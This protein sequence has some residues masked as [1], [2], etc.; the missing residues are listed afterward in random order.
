MIK[1]LR[2]RL[3]IRGKIKIGG[4]G[5]EKKSKGSDKTYRR[6]VKY[7]HFV[8][9]RTDRGEDGNY[10]RD[11]D[12]MKKYGDNP[13]ELNV[14]FASNNIRDV[15]DDY[16]ALHN[17]KVFVCKGDGET[18]EWDE[19]AAGCEPKNLK[20]LSKGEDG[21]VKVRCNRLTCPYMKPRKGKDALCKPNAILR[22]MIKEAQAVGAVY[23]FRTTSWNSTAAL[24]ASF[25]SIAS[26]TK[27]SVVQR[28]QCDATYQTVYD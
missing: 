18:A 6:S 12:L 10:I 3:A 11:E 5:E 1:G 16:L 21:K 25:L 9:T 15:Y 19:K 26:E 8:I 27:V 7:S 13:A 17:G 24:R 2:A 4:L 20:V 23:E 28:K 22:L 14:T